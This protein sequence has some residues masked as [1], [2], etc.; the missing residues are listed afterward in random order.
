MVV[1]RFPLKLVR[2]AIAIIG[3]RFEFC[4]IN[5]SIRGSTL[6]KV[7][8]GAL[9]RLSHIPYVIHLHGSSYREFFSNLSRPQKAIVRSFFKSSAKVI[10]LG[11]VWKDFIADGIGVPEAD[12]VILPNAV[13]APETLLPRDEK[14]PPHILFLGQLGERKGVPELLQALASP[15]MNA[16]PWTATLAGDGDIALYRAQA[17]SLGI[18][19]RVNFPGWVGPQDVQHLLETAHILALPSHAENLP[20]SM[21]EGMGYGLCPVVTPVGAVTDVIRDGENG[22]LVP[23]GN[24][25]ALANALVDV[26]CDPDKRQRLATQARADFEANYDIRDYREKL[27]AIYLDVCAQDTK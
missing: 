8:F 19:D 13:F 17:Q 4:H 12:I 16:L 26:V 14:A 10:V 27:E 24:A 21:L 18:A 6:R 11:T 20:L 2:F 7:L 22:L 25:D 5:L 23:V 3:N 15:E 9:C 1:L